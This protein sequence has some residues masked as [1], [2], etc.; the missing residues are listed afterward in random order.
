M[1]TPTNPTPDPT[2]ECIP[3]DARYVNDELSDKQI[4]LVISDIASCGP[5]LCFVAI[6]WVAAGVTQYPLLALPGAV[7]AGWVALKR[8][9]VDRRNVAVIRQC[10]AEK[11]ERAAAAERARD[12]ALED[13]LNGEAAA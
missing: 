1:T 13:L 3:L 2:P 6:S 10:A 12:E 8:A 4:D 11:A 9:V 7:L 5:E